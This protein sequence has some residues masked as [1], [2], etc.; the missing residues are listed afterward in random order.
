MEKE[1][2]KFTEITKTMIAD[3]KKTKGKLKEI[4]ISLDDESFD[5]NSKVAKFII[6]PPTRGT[7]SAI[8]HYGQEKNIDKVNELLLSNCVLGGDMKYLDEAT[9]DT[10]VFLSVLD[11]VGKLMEKK[12]VTSKNL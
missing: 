1:A 12:R 6:C 11:E 10:A 8:G 7:L 4:S 5:K 2:Q 9:G 3:W